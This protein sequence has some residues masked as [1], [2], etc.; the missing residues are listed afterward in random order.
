MTPDAT[1]VEALARESI[2]YMQ[3]CLAELAGSR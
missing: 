2:T 1:S 3:H